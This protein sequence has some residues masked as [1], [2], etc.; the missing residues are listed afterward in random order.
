MNRLL[1]GAVPLFVVLEGP[2]AG[3]FREPVALRALEAA[4]ARASALP[5][6]A[7]T[8]SLVTPLQRMNRVM[9][10]D[11]PAEERLPDSRQAVAELLNLMPKSDLGRLSTPNQG[12]TNLVVRTGEVGSAAVKRLTER[13]EATVSPA[14]FPS[15][16][17]VSVTGNAILLGRSAD[18]IAYGQA[19]SVGLAALTILVL[20][21]ALLRSWKLGLVAMAP[22]AV[23]VLL[24]FGL[25]GTGLAPLSLPTSLIAS[26]ALGIAIDDTVH[27]VVRYRHE[28]IAGR[29]P[30]EAVEITSR[31]VGRP[32]L[33]AA[34]MLILGFLSV[35]LSG[36]ASLRE[37]GLLSAATMGLC[38]VTDLVLLPALLMRI[39]A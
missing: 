16:T 12:R 33:V 5:G 11:D 25:L 15:G 17:T 4:E 36:F 18:A 38:L 24:F 22:N 3:T 20:L 21:T 30:R 10:E 7:H 8:S 6:V 2:E 31:L 37:F 32:M 35:A 23:P 19:N 14:D 1:A 28:R 34:A 27:Y 9:E 29:T 13:L 39:R 26:V